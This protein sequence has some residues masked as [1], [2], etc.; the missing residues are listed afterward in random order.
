M[1]ELQRSSASRSRLPTSKPIPAGT[2]IKTQRS[3]LGLKACWSSPIK[4]H[5][6]RVIGT[7]AFYFRST[8]RASKLEKRIVE[9][10]THVC[11]LAIEHWEAHDHIRKLA[12]TD[13]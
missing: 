8:R 13:P 12:F 3:S 4:I 7:F 6:G 9:S 11:S 1:Q 5:D 10:C 2:I